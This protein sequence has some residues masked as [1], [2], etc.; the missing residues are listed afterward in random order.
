MMP[1][2]AR[3]NDFELIEAVQAGD[4][5]AFD[6]MATK[7]HRFIAK[8][9]HRF[10]LAYDFDDLHQE[11]LMVLY[12]SALAF[13][14]HRYK[15]TFTRYFETNFKRHLMSVIRTRKHRRHIEYIHEG[16]IR[17]NV[18]RIQETSAYH[19]L[20]LAEVKKVLTECEYRVYILREMR[21]ASITLIARLTGLDTKAIYNAVHRAK[22]KIKAHYQGENLDK[23]APIW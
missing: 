17:E 22:A 9:I 6:W 15:K 5:A 11:G 4:T 2:R 16:E 21:H 1:A 13:D 8:I 14:Q 12:R 19:T 3:L 23:S 10:N 18:H 20:H 7:Y